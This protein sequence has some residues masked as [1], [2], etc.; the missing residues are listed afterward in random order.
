MRHSR[1][2]LL[3]V[4]I[5]LPRDGWT[6]SLALR[7]QGPGDFATLDVP[8]VVVHHREFTMALWART[9]AIGNEQRLM[10]LVFTDP[11][12]RVLHYALSLDSSSR[13]AIQVEEIA[14]EERQGG[15]LTAR[16]P[17]LSDDQW[18]HV[19]GTM[20][21]GRV[22]LFVDGQPMADTT[23]DMANSSW[24]AGR[25]GFAARRIDLG[26][27]RDLIESSALPSSPSCGF[28]GEMDEIQVWNAAL[29]P[30]E[31]IMYMRVEPRTE[32]RRLGAWW[33]RGSNSNDVARDATH[34]CGDLRLIGRASWGEPDSPVALGPAP[35][36][37]PEALPMRIEPCGPIKAIYR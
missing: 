25:I 7:F 21:E 26:T 12:G 11:E 13:A 29:S 10:D 5:F 22:T 37:P 24:E 16:G 34:R 14:G 4:L 6:G 17:A 30:E 35:P 23:L 15:W 28:S 33:R 19:A 3:I 31:V 20:R 1:H 8:G 36:P 32:D 27:C 18:H 9:E 2:I